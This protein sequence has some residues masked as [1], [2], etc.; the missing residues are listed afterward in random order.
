MTL[1]IT[2]IPGADSF[3]IKLHLPARVTHDLAVDDQI[4]VWL[5]RPTG[6]R[7]THVLIC[8]GYEAIADHWIDG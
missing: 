6:E 7:R 5:S 8:N 2:I 3:G 1:P 4:E